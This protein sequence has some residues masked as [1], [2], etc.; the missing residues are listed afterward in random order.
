[1]ISY[2]NHPHHEA[3]ILA[4]RYRSGSD[5]KTRLITGSDPISVELGLSIS[6]NPEIC[7]RTSSPEHRS[8]AGRSDGQFFINMRSATRIRGYFHTDGFSCSY[9]IFI[10]DDGL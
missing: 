5:F 9:S 4:R 2:N 3:V 8:A 10:N 7:D 1:M 6:V